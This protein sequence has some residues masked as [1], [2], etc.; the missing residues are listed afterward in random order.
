MSQCDET[1]TIK[2]TINEAFNAFSEDIITDHNDAYSLF[3]H[4]AASRK[5]NTMSAFVIVETPNKLYSTLLKTHVWIVSSKFFKYRNVLFSQGVEASDCPCDIGIAPLYS[6][7]I[8][9]IHSVHIGYR[10]FSPRFRKQNL[11]KNTLEY[12]HCTVLEQCC[13]YNLTTDF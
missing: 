6:V 2:P 3:M 7:H 5:H 8:T 13:K 1:K 12:L 11:C 9:V 4:C 10:L